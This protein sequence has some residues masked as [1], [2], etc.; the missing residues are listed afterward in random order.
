MIKYYVVKYFLKLKAIKAAE[1][2]KKAKEATDLLKKKQ[3]FKN[4]PKK[5]YSYSTLTNLKR[6]V[7][8]AK[9]PST[10]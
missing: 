8:P 1:K 7:K 10:V 6:E 3:A 2:A 4:Q 5:N 9:A